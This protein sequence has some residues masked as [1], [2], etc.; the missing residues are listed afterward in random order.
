MVRGQQ[1]ASEKKE[2]A[3]RLRSEMTPAERVLWQW[4]RA[5]RMRGLQFR[6]QQVIAGY[7]A[8]FYCN[9][10]GMVVE[11]DG[12]VH[13]EQRDWDEE[14]QKAIEAHNLTVLRFANDE[15]L[16]GLASVLERIGAAID[17]LD[18]SPSLSPWR[19]E[20]R[21]RQPDRS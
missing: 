16:G 18:P 21:R 14:R 10:V 19:G 4:L 6:R 1:V 13:N 8:D 11:V 3:K 17:A 2:F 9:A 20:E 7:I 5:N 15:V 12:T